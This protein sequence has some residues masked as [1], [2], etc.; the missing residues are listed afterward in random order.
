MITETQCPK[1]EFEFEVSEWDNGKCPK[2]EN[3]YM[4]TEL[5]AQDYS[6]SWNI[7]LWE[8]NNYQY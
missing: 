2:C 7:I 1:C 6:D 4:W 8:S 5:V 3:K